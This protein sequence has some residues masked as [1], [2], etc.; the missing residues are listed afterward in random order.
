ML[1]S[2]TVALTATSSK[3]TCG[4]FA[5]ISAR[6]TGPFQNLDFRDQVVL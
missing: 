3:T 5:A 4:V 6:D 2:G 1:N